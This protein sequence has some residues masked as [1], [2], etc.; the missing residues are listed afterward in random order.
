MFNQINKNKWKNGQ[1]WEKNFWDNY[2][3]RAWS[4]RRLNFLRSAIKIILRDGPGDDSNYWWAKQFDDYK[5]IPQKMTNVIEVGCG[6]FTNLRIALKDKNVTHVIASD[7]L[8]KHYVKYSTF[9]LA[10]KW[11]NTEYMIDDHPIEDLPYADN[12]FDLVVCINVLDHVL[13]PELCLKRITGLVR[14][15]GIVVFGQD[16]TNEED[17]NK[18]QTERLLANDMGHP[19]I[20]DNPEELFSYF[21]NFEII[22]KKILNRQ[23][24]RAPRWHFGTLI[25]A[26]CKKEPTISSTKSQI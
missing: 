11:R 20:F 18:T 9:Q 14:C 16:L 15:G 24:G 21:D 26:G 5:F 1:K 13:N 2:T 22:I 23:E 6:P 17:L 4:L 3:K 7:P 10:K 25:Y 8:A 19:H 12:Y